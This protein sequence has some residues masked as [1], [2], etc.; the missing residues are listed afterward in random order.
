MADRLSVFVFG[1]SPNLGPTMGSYSLCTFWLQPWT[2]PLIWDL[3]NRTLRDPRD[4]VP[5][6]ILVPTVSSSRSMEHNAHS[7]RVVLVTW[8]YR[9]FVV[10]G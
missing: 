1:P 9:T 3:L 4:I 6:L 10:L 5:N 8:Q 7:L 2:I